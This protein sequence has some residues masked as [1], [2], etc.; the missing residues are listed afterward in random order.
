MRAH[1]APLFMRAGM[2]AR[3]HVS[4]Y[5]HASMRAHVYESTCVQA[6]MK[7]ASPHSHAHLHTLSPRHACG[8]RPPTCA[9]ASGWWPLLRWAWRAPLLP[10][11][12]APAYTC[13]LGK[14]DVLQLAQG[15]WCRAPG[16]HPGPI[17][18]RA[19]GTAYGMPSGARGQPLCLAAR[20]RAG[21]QWA[22]ARA[23]RQ[24]CVGCGKQRASPPPTASLLATCNQPLGRSSCLA[25]ASTLY[26]RRQQPLA[27]VMRRLVPRGAWAAPLASMP[28]WTHTSAPSRTR[29]CRQ[30][31]SSCC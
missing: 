7:C 21:G 29:L 28:P 20:R 9:G 12:G 5:A 30:R 4:A 22:R 18:A 16:H 27:G 19:G 8:C 1:V 23:R 17:N 2:H 15:A 26:A 14:L 25:V 24:R 31:C 11:T 3:T 6:S 10:S 13:V